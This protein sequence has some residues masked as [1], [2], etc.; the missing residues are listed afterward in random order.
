MKHSDHVMR[1][2]TALAHYTETN[3]R[4]AVDEP[5]NDFEVAVNELHEMQ[6][7][8]Q[9][10][11]AIMKPLEADEKE[12]RQAMADSLIAHFGE[13]LKEGMND[14]ELSNRR[15]LKFKHGV[16]RSIDAGMIAG[17]RK[18]YSETGEPTPVA[19]DDL[20]R[21]KYDLDKTQWKKLLKGSAAFNAFAQCMTAK[22]SSPS[23][24]VD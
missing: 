16:S 20:L 10:M 21:P 11:K 23:I 9:A 14:Y 15:K 22:P 24:E 1:I 2:N 7:L 5:A 17:A 6:T 4:P 19:F 3:H 13:G 12:M 18:A 8:L